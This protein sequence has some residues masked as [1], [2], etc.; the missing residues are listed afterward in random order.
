MGLL[1]GL[2]KY[3]LLKRVINGVMGRRRGRTRY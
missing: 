3:N 1:T 2:V